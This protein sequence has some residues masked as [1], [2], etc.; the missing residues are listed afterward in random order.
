MHCEAESNCVVVDWGTPISRDQHWGTQG[1][2]SSDPDVGSIAMLVLYSQVLGAAHVM[3][4]MD[5][6]RS[7]IMEKQLQEFKWPHKIESIFVNLFE[8]YVK[9]KH[10]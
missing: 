2:A 1:S 8:I 3:D 5:V 9:V 7:D 4:G 10:Q 6:Q